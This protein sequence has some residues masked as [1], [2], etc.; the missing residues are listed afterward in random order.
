M[1]VAVLDRSELS[2][3]LA[4]RSAVFASVDPAA[5]L[6]LA[7]ELSLDR[8]NPVAV[9]DRACGARLLVSKA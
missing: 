9:P 3:R 5:N 7:E 6:D 1:L 4:D 2:G 8:S